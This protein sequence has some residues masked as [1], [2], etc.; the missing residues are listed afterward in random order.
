[1]PHARIRCPHCSWRPDG[2]AYWACACGHVWD[3][4]AT[5]A[6]CPACKLRQEMTFCPDC[7]VASPH[8]HWY[9]GYHGVMDALQ[10]DE[11]VPTWLRGGDVR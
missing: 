10:A 3:V 1:M 5:Q 2:A 6:R 4:F 11:D 8:L 7:C 9:E